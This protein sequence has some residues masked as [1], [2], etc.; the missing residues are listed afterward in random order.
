MKKGLLITL[1]SLIISAFGFG[2]NDII[3][4]ILAKHDKRETINLEKLKKNNKYYNPNNLFVEIGGIGML[5]SINY[6]VNMYSDNYKSGM[7][8][9]IGFSP[10]YNTDTSDRWFPNSGTIIPIRW[11]MFYRKNEHQYL[12]GIGMIP[13][14]TSGDYN[15]SQLF[16]TIGYMHIV[17]SINLNIGIAIHPTFVPPDGPGFPYPGLRIGYYL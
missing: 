6:E 11:N 9:G 17:P 8:F 10:V 3:K 1:F 4:T 15:Y 13:N 16:G 12:L 2:Q 14:F 5:S 7:S